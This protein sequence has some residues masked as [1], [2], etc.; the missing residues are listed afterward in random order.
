MDYLK[1]I[2]T[3]KPFSNS[4]RMIVY[5]VMRNHRDSFFVTYHCLFQ[6]KIN[7]TNTI[8]RDYNKV[9]VVKNLGQVNYFILADF[10]NE[11]IRTFYLFMAT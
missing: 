9:W 8:I 2:Y 11:S 7:L 1:R 5:L 3:H 6:C 4:L 10:N